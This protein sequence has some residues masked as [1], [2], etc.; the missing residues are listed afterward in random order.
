MYSN[1]RWPEA[2]LNGD[3]AYLGAVPIAAALARGAMS[4]SPAAWSTAPWCWGPLMHEF[5]LE[6]GRLRP[7]G[8][9]QHL[10]HLPGMRRTGDRRLFTDWR[11]VPDWANIGY[12]I[13]ECR[14][15]GSAGQ[16]PK[17]PDTGGLV[18]VGLGGRAIAPMRSATRS[19]ICCPM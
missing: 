12:P 5:R 17:A 10:G 13:A 4:S 19:A 16:S 18:S 9:G 15:D 2:K 8:G 11:D 6:D 7:A 3:H 1:E 14:A